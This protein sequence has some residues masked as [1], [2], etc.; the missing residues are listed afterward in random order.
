M[1]VETSSV[2]LAEAARR[3][4][5]FVLVVISGR[6]DT[7][8]EG[9]RADTPAYARPQLQSLAIV[10]VFTADALVTRALGGPRWLTLVY[11]GLGL[12]LAIGRL[13]LSRGRRMPEEPTAASLRVVPSRFA[14]PRRLAIGYAQ[15][16]VRGSLSALAADRTAIAAHA[17]THGLELMTV[18][19]DIERD[20]GEW[21]GRPALSWALD[22]IADE[23]AEVLVVA[24]LAHL[25]ESVAEL[26]ELLGWFAAD[27]RT[28]VAIDLQLDVS[29]DDSLASAV[30]QPQP[31]A[32]RRPG[33]SS[34]RPAVADR[35]ELQQRILAMREKG[36]TLQAIADVLN[37]DGV[38]TARG[39]AMWRPSSVQRAAGYQRPR[40]Q[41]RG[42]EMTRR[43]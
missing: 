28:L 30:S 3:W 27:G 39:G 43:S 31:V 12:V 14:T 10:V 41:P 19:H 1:R 23:D 37:G 13:A 8:G 9:R 17:Q 36:M 26:S 5:P 42:I 16:G 18:V 24:R 22:R 6:R 32:A 11:I 21:D 15:V 7:G 34:R 40:R 20:P 2:K 25:S 38:P 33:P 4:Y 29:T 35:P